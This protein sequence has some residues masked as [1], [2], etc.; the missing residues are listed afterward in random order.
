MDSPFWIYAIGLSAQVF[1]SGRILIQW[2]LSEK[3]KTVESPSLFW[4]FSIIG[5]MIMFLYGCLRN[6]FSIIFGELFT[7]YIYMWN[8]KAKGLYE[9]TPRIVP[10]LQALIPVAALLFLMRDIPRFAETFLHNE[11]VPMRLLL[12]GVAG[13]VV[14]KSR[15]IYQWIYGVRHGESTLPLPFW[16]IAVA[17]SL[18]IITYGAIRHDWV[19]IL[20]QFGIIASIRNIMI[21]L[22]YD[23]NKP[24][25]QET[26]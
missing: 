20:G 13:Q 5:S 15:F 9:K 12:F 23:K 1:Y 3:H 16:I 2:F 18:M 6:D 14:F 21:S 7:Y 19:L 22:K 17:G 10:I 4:V 26:V 8:I 11:D 24:N 25:G